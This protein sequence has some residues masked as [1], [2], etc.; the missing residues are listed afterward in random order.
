MNKKLKLALLAS[1]TIFTSLM[2]MIGVVNPAHAASP[3]IR[4]KNGEACVKHPHIS[5]SKFVC[6]RVT[7]ANQGSQSAP[8]S[9]FNSATPSDKNVAMLNFSEADSDKAIAL[10]GCDCP[11]CMNALRALQGQAP[12]VY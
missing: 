7:Q 5:Y 8:T 1:P 4:M 10:F 9:N 11:Y 3:V 12:M 6:M 2:T